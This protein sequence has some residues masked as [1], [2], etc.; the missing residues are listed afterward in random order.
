MLVS[1][2]YCSGTHKRGVICSKR[3]KDRRTKDQDPSY[4]F[5]FRSSR[6]WQVKRDEIKKRDKYLCALCRTK[7]KYVFDR[8]AVHHIRPIKTAWA[9][10]LDE[11][12]LITL[13][14]SCHE[15]AEKGNVCSRILGEIV[16]KAYSL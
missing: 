4:V 6:A 11:F 7:G 9:Y 10:R 1:C 16:E 2:S 8:L 13:C 5:R 14:R 3:P 15:D 12:N